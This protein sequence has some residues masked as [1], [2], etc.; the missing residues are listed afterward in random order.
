MKHKLAL[1]MIIKAD[2]KEVEYL[3]RCLSNI[4]PFVDKT[5]ITITGKNKKIEEVCKLFGAEI[6]YFE[7][8]NDFS[9]ARNY[10]FSQVPKEYDYIMWADADDVFR[11]LDKLRETIDKNLEID[12]FSMYYL[13][14]FDEEKNPIVVHMKTMIVRNDGC[15]EWAGA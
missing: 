15:V 6:S 7:W 3:K 12:A 11:G 14:A 9:K 2:D 5:F 10:S 1:A 8:V 13:Y 4:T